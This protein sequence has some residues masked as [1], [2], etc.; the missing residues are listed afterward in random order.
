MWL[1]M[2][3]GGLGQAPGAPVEPLTW[4]GG[5]CAAFIGWVAHALGPEW[6]QLDVPEP[7]APAAIVW[8]AVLVGGARIA[9]LAL[10]RRSTMR[11]APRPPTRV[12]LVTAGASVLT[13]AAIALTGSD[14]NDA[15]AREP[16]L[17]IRI[18][19]VGQGDAILVQPH[20]RKPLLIDTGPPDAETGAQLADLGVDELSAIAI[21]HD[22]LDHSGGLAS[23][24]D[25]VEA[26]RLLAGYGPPQGCRFLDCPPTTRVAA[27]SRF[28]LGRARAEV[29]WP[30]P[31]IPI[32]EDPNETSLVLLL[33]LGDF[34]ALLTADAE[35]EAAT[36]GSGPVEFLKL[37]HHGSAD[38]G[39]DPLLERTSPEFAAISVGADNTYGHP[40]PETTAA[41]EDHEVPA[42]RTD[43][44]GE[45]VVE[46]RGDGW[47]VR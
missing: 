43:E 24:L 7:S 42:L 18:L 4:L 1:G 11:P 45:I 6:A 22:E 17:T 3:S 28:R 32:A 2:L 46:V 5:L 37:A 21:T 33:S 8:T 34:D 20:G 12:V 19:D 25:E 15:P 35:S 13:I 30:P 23:V 14:E 31:G 41:L 38:S 9:C 44:A 10:E 16:A 27:G 47:T 26:R 40:A 29:L 39:L 36:Y